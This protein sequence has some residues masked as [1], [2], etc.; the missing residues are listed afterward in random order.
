[1]RPTIYLETSIISYLA[2]R[3]SRDVIAA[4]RQQLT[5]EWWEKRRTSYDV[6]VSTLVVE[7]AELGDASAAAQRLRILD[8]LRLVAPPPAAEDLALLLMHQLPLPSNAAPDAAHIAIAATVGADYLLTW[9]FKH[10]ANATLREQIATICRNSGHQSPTI[11]T[12]E[13]LLEGTI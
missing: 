9:N 13:E 10:I 3:P 2:A 5:V 7:E 6:F 4:A 8:G 11:C 12:P 1:M